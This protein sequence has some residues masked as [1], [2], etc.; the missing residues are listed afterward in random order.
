VRFVVG[1]SKLWKC[2]YKIFLASLLNVPSRFIPVINFEY[3]DII[4][5][6]LSLYKSFHITIQIQLVLCLYNPMKIIAASKRKSYRE[7]S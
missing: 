7:T 5:A 1:S 2:A 4:Y 6:C 3:V